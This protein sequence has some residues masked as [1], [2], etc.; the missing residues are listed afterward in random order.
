MLENK[1]TC[2]GCGEPLDPQGDRLELKPLRGGIGFYEKRGESLTTVMLTNFSLHF[3]PDKEGVCV[4][5]Y[6]LKQIAAQKEKDAKKAEAQKNAAK[7]S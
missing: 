2:D 3:C 1:M 5:N 7:L 4:G 6:L